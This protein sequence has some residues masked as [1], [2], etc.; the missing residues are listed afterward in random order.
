M[1]KNIRDYEKKRAV[2]N[3][4]PEA[5]KVTPLATTL[6]EPSLLK[7]KINMTTPPI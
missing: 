3:T 2:M 7:P 6:L 1:K 4:A 5:Q